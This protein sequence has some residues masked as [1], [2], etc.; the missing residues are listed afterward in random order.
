MVKRLTPTGST[1]QPQSVANKGRM[2]QGVKEKV[3]PLLEAGE[4]KPIIYKSFPLTAAAA[5]HA[6]LERADHVGKVMLAVSLIGA[7]TSCSAS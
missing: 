2:A 7:R 3:W 4:I 6:E 1:L 5:A